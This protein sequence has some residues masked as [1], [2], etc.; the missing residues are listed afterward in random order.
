MIPKNLEDSMSKLTDAQWIKVL[1]EYNDHVDRE[2]QKLDVSDAKKSALS[3]NDAY[4]LAMS[5]K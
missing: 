5:K 1:Q 4:M 2:L 3:R